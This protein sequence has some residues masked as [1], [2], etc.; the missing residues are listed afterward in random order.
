MSIPA[1]VLFCTGL[2]GILC[3]GLPIAAA[4]WLRRRRQAL[5]LCFV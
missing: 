5:R 4:V 3:A 2:T 1:F